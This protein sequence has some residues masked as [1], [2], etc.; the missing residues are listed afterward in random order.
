MIQV[1]IA[2]HDDIIIE[3]STQQADRLLSILKKTVA[4]HKLTNLEVEM[5][6]Q[7]MVNLKESLEDD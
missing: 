2:M 1:N 4:L 5:F 3:L 6:D 7:L